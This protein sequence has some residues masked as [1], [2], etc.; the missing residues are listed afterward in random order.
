FAAA[1]IPLAHFY[2]TPILASVLPV[3]GLFFILS[4]LQSMA[5]PLLQKRMQF[6]RLNAFDAVMD[7]FSSAA[8]I[9][10][11]YFIQNIW[12]LVFGGL[13]TAAGRTVASHFLIRDVRPKLQI[14]RHYASHIFSFGKWIF[15][16]SAIYFLSSN[17]D[18]LYYAKV[19]G[20]QM[21]G[22]YGIAR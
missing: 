16:S 10:I 21:L 22:V 12:A 2:N 15:L 14:T 13:M 17:F 20:L 7:V 1:S 5:I 6:V 8:H 19:V 18:R 4:A 9:G 11:A 3:A